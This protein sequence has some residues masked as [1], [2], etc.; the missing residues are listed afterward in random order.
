M[1]ALGLTLDE[2]TEVLRTCRSIQID[3]C[4]PPYL[5]D[6]IAARLETAFPDLD[7]RKC[8]YRKGKWVEE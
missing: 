6:F 2:L 4:T 3:E 8:R 5:Q 7:P 1:A